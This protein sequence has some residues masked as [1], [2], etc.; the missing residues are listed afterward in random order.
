MDLKTRGS[1]GNLL[2]MIDHL[3][4]YSAACLIE[5]KRKETIKRGEWITES[6][7]SVA[8]NTFCQ[9]MAVNL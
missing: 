6:K 4:R 7:F 5:N 9:T 1:D 2:H 8:Q 3:T